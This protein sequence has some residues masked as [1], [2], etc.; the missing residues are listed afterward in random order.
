MIMS[1]KF[2]FG[3]VMVTI[4]LLQ[5]FIS[6]QNCKNGKKYNNDAIKDPKFYEVGNN[7]ILLN[8]RL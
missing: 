4:R 6:L 8:D 5:L 7:M 2:H 1:L 3:K